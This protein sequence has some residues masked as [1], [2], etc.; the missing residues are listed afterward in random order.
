MNSRNQQARRWRF[1][2][3]CAS[4]VQFGRRLLVVACAAFATMPL[5]VQAQETVYEAV[6]D[7]YEF[8]AQTLGQFCRP[9]PNAPL[10]LNG[11]TITFN[12]RYPCASGLNVT[13]TVT[14]SRP[15]R[16]S[17]VVRGGE[18]VLTSPVTPGVSAQATFQNG[19]PTAL[20]KTRVAAGIKF[21]EVSNCTLQP[22]DETGLGPNS[23]I[24]KEGSGTCSLDAMDLE[25]EA[26]R[27][28]KFAYFIAGSFVTV[29]TTPSTDT[30]I[31]REVF[32]YVYYRFGPAQPAPTI[33]GLD[34]KLAA[35]GSRILL[36]IRG[37]GFTANSRPEFL[38]ANS[39]AVD[40]D[41]V[42]SEVKFVSDTEI[43][44]ILSV[45]D[46]EL[47]GAGGDAKTL[48]VTTGGNAA[49]LQN[50]LSITSF[51]LAVKHGN[52]TSPTRV[53]IANHPTMVRAKMETPLSGPGV[54]NGMSGLLYVFQGEAQ[55]DGSP[56][57]PNKIA[58]LNCEILRPKNTYS[59]DD[60]AF[61]CDR[62]NFYFGL[63]FHD[64]TYDPLKEGGYSF[65][66]AVS[67]TD[68]AIPPLPLS[69]VSKIDLTARRDFI[70]SEP[71]PEQKFVT[72]RPLRIILVVDS[73]LSEERADALFNAHLRDFQYLAAAYPIDGSPE[74]LVVQKTRAAKFVKLDE[75]KPPPG[76]LLKWD[77]EILDRLTD[78]LVYV[79]S[80]RA[81]ERQFDRIALLVEPEDLIAILGPNI[82]GEALLNG[83][84]CIYGNFNDN[85]LAH[86]IGHTLGL[87]DTYKV[88]PA[89][90]A[91]NGTPPPNPRRSDAT[92][93]GNLVEDGVER[94]APLLRDNAIYPV[95][96][97]AV[98]ADGEVLPK[99][100][101]RVT[102]L[103]GAG[104]NRWPDLV[105]RK[106]LY[107]KFRLPARA[108]AAKSSS[109]NTLAG[110]AST[111]L[112]YV[113]G[114]IGINDQVRVTAVRRATL[115]PPSSEPGDFI[116]ELLDGSGQVL[117]ATSFGVNFYKPHKGL[118]NQAMFSVSTAYVAGA[119]TVRI[120]KGGA[121]LF[122]QSISANAPTVQIQ[123]PAGG[124][125]LGGPFTI[126]WSGSD[127]DSDPL[128]Y[129]I[130]YLRDEDSPRPIAGGLSN[131]SFQWDDPSLEGGSFSGRIIVTAT[132]GFYETSAISAPFSVARRGP[133]VMILEP[134][135]GASVP[136]GTQSVLT[137][138]GSD[139]E[140]GFLP[141]GSLSFR[142][143]IDGDLGTGGT[144]T[145]AFSQGTHTI[146]L[147][148]VDS[149]GVPAE[150]SITLIVGAAVS[151]PVV[152][153]SSPAAGRAGTAV[154]LNGR[155]FSSG[156]TVK[157]GS[158]AAQVV[159]VSASQ[160]VVTVPSGLPLGE[161]EI[162]VTSGGFNT[163][164]ISFQVIYGRPF[165]SGLTP[166]SGS[167]GTPV[168]IGGA[169]FATTATGNT[170][171]FGSATATV[172]G[173]GLDG[174]L[175]TVPA[176]LNAGGTSVTV[177]TS[178]GVSDP[179]P[180]T[181]TSGQ[182]STPVIINSISPPSAPVGATV[183][184]NGSGFSNTVNNNGV[185]FGGISVTPTSGSGNSLQ[186]IVPFG[187]S[188]GTV[189]LIVTVNG[190]PSNP[191]PF[192]VST[193][194]NPTPTP[195]CGTPGKVA[196]ASS[197]D[198]NNEIY[199]MNPD[200]SGQVRLTNNPALDYTPAFSPDG[201][202]I[203]FSSDRDGNQEIYVMNADGSG[204]TRLTNNPALD[205]FPAWSP[206]G[207]RIAFTR[208]VTA[209]N[210]EV[211]LM[212]ANGTGEANITNNPANDQMPAWSPDGSKLV[213][214]SDRDD[215][216]LELYTMNPNGSGVTRL[217][218]NPGG[219]D[220]YPA[221][222][223]DGTKIAFTT[224][225]VSN[226]HSYDFA[227]EVFV[228][229][230]N[231]TNQTNL[232]NN[233]RGDLNP[234][235][236]PDGSKII[237]A[238][239]RSSAQ[240]VPQ[241]YSMNS[242]GTGVTRLTNNTA[243]DV[244]P[245]WSAAQCNPTSAVREVQNISTRVVVG[246]GENV[247]IGGFIVLGTGAKRV[248]VRAIGPSLA[249]F[250][251]TGALEDPTLELF[252]GTGSAIAFNDD[253]LSGGQNQEI[254][255]LL[256]PGDRVEA[257]II[258]SLTPGNYTAVLRGYENGTGIALVEVY[259]LD[260]AAPSRLAN[261]STRGQVGTGGS[262]LIG[263]FI[264]GKQAQ[265]VVR[266]I[267]PFLGAVGI[268][269]ALSNPVLDLYNGQGAKLDTNDNWQD[270]PS[271]NQVSALGLAPNNALESA[272]IHTLPAGNYTAIVR[273]V[274]DGVGVGLVE[275]YSLQ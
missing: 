77:D 264:V 202:R 47:G 210:L 65:V 160:I 255:A 228:M 215:T 3:A 88:D 163:N 52:E 149:D 129:S 32:A 180:F 263:G 261:I 271:A 145:P 31:L 225:R 164:H 120:R 73:R 170:V 183:T 35:R 14:F 136:A 19:S 231:G 138:A 128:T 58:F 273:G 272:V 50:A 157:F 260:Q 108:V 1:T 33:T 159:S 109:I 146:T 111:D 112:V 82:N 247:A 148:G 133:V 187:L 246:T 63:G 245:A 54:P 156:A 67:P 34:Q 192:T 250:G 102:S 6:F 236:A 16:I 190:Y 241:L 42:I 268:G 74:K 197:R 130:L 44:A 45:A 89:P 176:G 234:A 178:Q 226:P 203:A 162:F 259:D 83:T 249:N 265:F 113:Q 194:T 181:V 64:N 232:T 7:R 184:I 26:D 70:V 240:Y 122:S 219:V 66:L 46:D 93:N 13:G 134:K 201:T 92:D 76:S 78:T 151:V 125:T 248:I 95:L 127:P 94:L 21:R 41:L 174:L 257:S 189:N 150:T 39:G 106:Y 27:T 221:W 239:D 267:G 209:T 49:T 253:W 24:T 211:F 198:G 99:V 119:T 28:P 86:E 43:Q 185:S 118:V 154:T 96:T 195:G 115:P 126:S 213:F 233:G 173:A 177:T 274:N 105:E 123:S 98:N 230:A 124:E 8:T 217:T 206:D 191:L 275:V 25:Y 104:F 266:A 97:A 117:S 139:A 172:L 140:D 193:G 79:N 116:L 147:R 269:N 56:F 107:D 75:L 62:L 51:D 9:F 5:A 81:P 205:Y 227:L 114:F 186:V 90:A 100:P 182:P 208:Q 69:G 17:G 144:I 101:Y 235:W 171:V 23:T 36:N 262:V 214:A 59:P 168:F 137:G 10:T 218:N 87:I 155:N 196:F 216:H 48:R 15:D 167:P 251:V 223:P 161:S 131:T 143:S 18:F 199:L 220:Y 169:E 38:H 57:L 110:T 135:D 229:N 61:L 179:L 37:T 60:R 200:G 254:A 2:A 103:M 204:Q 237:F 84:A 40:D 224:D 55:I 29:Q 72:T 152:D 4:C 207:A 132:D 252:N 212:N 165:L 11:D 85:T 53:R 142:S 243:A 242:N 30:I 256:P 166:N 22:S 270:N 12:D 80:R 175:V 91:P 222:S 238:S 141:G 258:A 244:S 158:T 71:L 20:H 188:A 68:P 153:S 121:V